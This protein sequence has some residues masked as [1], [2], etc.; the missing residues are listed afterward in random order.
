MESV[1]PQQR[2]ALW[3]AEVE[4]NARQATATA[5]QTT[6]NLPLHVNSVRDGVVSHFIA[7]VPNVIPN[8]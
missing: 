5:V 6:V 7:S 2:E 4:G 8:T 3:L 1:P